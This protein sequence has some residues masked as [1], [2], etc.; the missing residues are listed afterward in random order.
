MKKILLS[1]GAAALL[2]TA[3]F[4]Q[5][6]SS[7]GPVVAANVVLDKN[8]PETFLAAPNLDQI[9]LEDE[10][11]DRNGQ[12]YRIGVTQFTNITT[13]NS[14][15]WKT[16]PNGD[17]TWQLKVKSPGAEA[18]SFLFETFKMY[19]NS[20]LT[21]TDMSGVLRHRPMT[22]ADMLDHFYQNAALCFG[23]EF[24]LT[25]TEPFGSRPSEIFING[26][27]YNYRSTGNPMIH[28]INESESCEVNVNCSPV[29]DTWQ[30]EKRGVARI[31]VVEGGGAGWCTG[32]LVNNVAQDCKPLMLT[33]LHCG[34]NA[35][36]A[37]LNQWRFLFKYES[38]N[39]TNPGTAGTLDDYFITG[40]VKL[41]SSN[42]GGGNSG[43]DFLLLQMGT[44][45]N[46][47]A[48][49]TTLKTANFNAYWNGWD[50]NN[51]VTNAGSSIH[52]PAGDIKKIS[53]FSSNLVTAG[54]NGNGLQSHWRVSWSANANGHGVTEGG[55]SGSPIFKTNGGNSVI[56]GTLTGGSS[57]CNALTSPDFY[58]KMSF[59][60]TS[61]G[62][63]ANE[64]LKTHL[65]PANT[66]TLLLLGSANPCTPTTPVVPVANFVAN[67]TNVAPAT[68]VSFTDQSTGVPTSWAWSVS[69]AT[70]WAYSGG[71]SASTQNPQITFNTVGQYTITLVATNA[72]GSDSE[73]KTNYITVAV[74]TGPCAGASTTCDEFIQNVSFN[75][76]NNTSACT[77][78]TSYS[79]SATVNKGNSYSM[80]IT[81][82][83]TGNIVGSSYI[84]NEIAAWIDFNND[85]TFANPGE[86]VFYVQVQQGTTAAQ[87]TQNATIPANAVTGSVK[88]RVRISFNGTTGGEGPVNPCGTT[89]YG[90]VEDYSVLIQN[91]PASTLTLSCGGN[92][93]IV[94][95][96]GGTTM[97]NMVAFASATT[98]CTST[99]VTG[100]QSP[101]IGT[102]LVSGAN[103]VTITAVD[104]CGS[105][106]TCQ[107]TVTYQND[108]GIGE[109]EMFNAVTV[110]PNP[111][112][113]SLM[114][115]LTSIGNE[116]VDI[117]IYD[118]AGKLL[119]TG[120]NK[121]NAIVS[122]DMSNL[123][124]GMYQVKL[125]TNSA[126]TVRRITKL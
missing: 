56:I 86:R 117:E 105:T 52:H 66:G 85:G 50:A 46:Q 79:A 17:K 81:P 100:S 114:V 6:V 11:R 41:S 77:N 120:D 63:P 111:F 51:T 58:G 113:A 93:T 74:S 61:N 115:D 75:T 109:A 92:Q 20:S 76:I 123:S 26:V 124:Q 57:F 104:Q 96:T 37:N 125:I 89:Q 48:T 24:V 102:A 78:Y 116:N 7:K 106:Q 90:E 19:D 42:D 43:S 36:T 12:L 10:Q 118:L 49:I 2:F 4:A 53:T 32:S 70:G 103:V 65:D 82:Q 62:T 25:L 23:D 40:S 30:D 68:T 3:S 47:A 94:A 31:Y 54:W 64:Q 27:I 16:L 1:F 44:L 59:H 69:P 72:Q 121:E 97:P 67:Q 14:G 5:N 34:V 107:V 73:V 88:M 80:T 95:S 18:L 22:A 83:I 21:I 84:G 108:L 9:R 101:A 28:K 126:Q 33:A 8:V 39:C 55:S 15:L 38:P 13:D 87:F 119:M 45:A 29:G 71:S 98:T 91:A 99:V 110:Y 122:F 35:T 112:S 60:W